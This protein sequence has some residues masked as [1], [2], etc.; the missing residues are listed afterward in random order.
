MH[1]MCRTT[2]LHSVHSKETKDS[3]LLS[4][5]SVEEH[6]IDPAVLILTMSSKAYSGVSQYKDFIGCLPVHLA[7]FILNLLD[8]TSLYNALCVN[9]KWRTL[10][11]EI[12]IEN[13]VKQDLR[14]EAMLMQV[15]SITHNIFVIVFSS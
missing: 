2:V 8:Q 14:E 1:E 7:L 3:E 4:S 5:N 9:D 11:E 6:S 13:R 15:G 10:A 12:R